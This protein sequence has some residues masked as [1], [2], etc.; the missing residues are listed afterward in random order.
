MNGISR[1]WR[2]LENI[3]TTPGILTNRTFTLLCFKVSKR[4][5]WSDAPPYQSNISNLVSGKEVH[6]KKFLKKIN[7]IWKKYKNVRIAYPILANRTILLYSKVPTPSSETSE[8]HS[9]V[10]TWSLEVGNIKTLCNKLI[11][12]DKFPKY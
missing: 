4:P 10:T 12:F 5:T 1:I 8:Y 6:K 2:K 7:R 11:E 3:R 9:T